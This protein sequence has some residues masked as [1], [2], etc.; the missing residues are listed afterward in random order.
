VA[1]VKQLDATY[2]YAMNKFVPPILQRTG[3]K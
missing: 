2:D 3:G 1:T